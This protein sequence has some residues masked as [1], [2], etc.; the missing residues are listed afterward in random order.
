[1]MK[2]HSSWKVTVRGRANFW[3]FSLKAN[4]TQ[5]CGDWERLGY[6]TVNC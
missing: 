2:G 3:W 1:M 4:V 6:V 5:Y